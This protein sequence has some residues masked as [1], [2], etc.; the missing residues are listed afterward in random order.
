MYFSDNLFR[1]TVNHGGGQLEKDG[2]FDY[3]NPSSL[4]AGN[5]W[6]PTPIGSITDY[7]GRSTVTYTFQNSVVTSMAYGTADPPYVQFSPAATVS[8]AGLVTS[9]TVPPNAAS[10]TVL[11]TVPAGSAR[12]VTFA[13]TT[14]SANFNSRIWSMAGNATAIRSV[15]NYNNA[16]WYLDKEGTYSA[17]YFADS[18]TPGNANYFKN[19]TLTLNPGNYLVHLVGTRFRYFGYTGTITIT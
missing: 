13:E 3:W 18:N 2:K 15:V 17:P 11:F 9:F 10:G 19:T 1:S 16:G 12:S 4:N 14:A 8:V 6:V 7:P 5:Y